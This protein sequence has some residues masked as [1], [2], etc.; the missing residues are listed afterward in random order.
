MVMSCPSLPGASPRE[1]FLV[2]GLVAAAIYSI[3]C[4]ASYGSYFVIVTLWL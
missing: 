1:K 3:A 2:M 4:F